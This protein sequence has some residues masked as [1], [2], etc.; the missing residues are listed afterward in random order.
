MSWVLE[1]KATTLRKHARH[2]KPSSHK[3]LYRQTTLDIVAGD[4]TPERKTFFLVE[5]AL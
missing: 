1:F 3:D 5:D 2:P 4:S